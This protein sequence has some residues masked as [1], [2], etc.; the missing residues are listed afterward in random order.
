VHLFSSSGDSGCGKSALLRRF[1]DNEFHSGYSSTIG[2]DFALRTLD[3]PTERGGNKVVK[4]QMW[5]TAGQERFRTITSS[6]Y[7]GAHAVLIVFDVTSEASFASVK[8]WLQELDQLHA[9]ANPEYA[10]SSSKGR[11][12]VGSSAA[13]TRSAQ[14]LLVANKT[15]L[16]RHRVVEPHRV[17]E[18][19]AELGIPFVEA[20]AKSGDGVGQA[21]QGVAAAFVKQRMIDEAEGRCSGA[22]G[23]PGMHGEKGLKVNGAAFGGDDDGAD[24]GSSWKKCFGACS[25]M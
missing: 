8:R 23:G 19:A 3:V 20:S 4:L 22:P 25:I 10:P 11:V 5:D 1:G 15:D 6:Y 12:N 21:F 16:F 13:V 17:A 7:R 14:V 18:L 24:G 2:V 9:Q